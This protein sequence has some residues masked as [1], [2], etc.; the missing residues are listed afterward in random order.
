[1][2][3]RELARWVLALRFEDIDEGTESY[4][5]E[6]IL[7]H[8]GCA[9]RGGVVESMPSVDRALTAIDAYSGSR[10]TAIVGKSPARPE[11]A[12]FSNAIAAHSIELDDT[13]SAA[14][15]HPA[16]VTIPGALAAA[17]IEGSSGA[18]FI[19]AIVA[20]YEVACRIG[21][22]LNPRD[23][24]ARGFHPTAIV[25]PFATAAAVGKLIGLTEEQLAH[26]FGIA[27]SQSAGST[28]F[29]AEGAWTKRFHPGWA[30]HAGY[31][32]AR[33]A[34]SGFTGPSAP[35]DG[36]DGLL[37]G[38]GSVDFAARIMDGIGAPFELAA[39]SVKPHACCRYNQGP[40]DLAIRL[41][42]EHGIAVDEVESIEVGVV[43]A[44]IAIV[45]EPRDRKIRP[46]NDVD[47]QFSLPYAVGLGLIKGQ[48]TLAEY[49]EPTMSDAGVLAVAERTVAVAKAKFDAK[50]PAIWP[51]DM[52][53]TTTDGRTLHAALEFAKGDPENRL[54]YD[55]M[56]AKFR[57]LAGVV[58]DAA[59]LDAIISAVDDLAV[60]GVGPVIA[61]VTK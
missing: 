11:W 14:S 17:E 56:C 48:A 27:S 60:G 33:L 23:V 41:Q 22:A 59:Q 40:I 39:T 53:I 54:T 29:L 52:T 15:L 35:F 58:F 46:T 34:Q 28:E 3:A 1:M 25:G 55:E 49:A 37:R 44:A 19:T 31:I 5:R 45:V 30:S 47:A 26:A 24:Y 50:Y 38:Y 18:E 36:R 4:A 9:A 7:D 8:L 2:I 61:A 10:L 42:R 20:G 57:L 6:L 32:A 13:H 12:M 16:V 21:R 51:C 43:S